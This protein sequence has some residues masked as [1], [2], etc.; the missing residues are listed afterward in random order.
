[1]V[2]S[3]AEENPTMTQAIL[4][5][6]QVSA[7]TGL[8]RSSI[9]LRIA[10]GIFPRPVSLGGTLTRA[11]GWRQTEIDEWLASLSTKSTQ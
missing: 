9:Y 4:R 7:C 3:E 5:L 11:V 8:S 10:Q 2:C 1:M 6:P